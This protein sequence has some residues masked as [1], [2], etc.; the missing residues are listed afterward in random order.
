M[1]ARFY[2]PARG[3]PPGVVLVPLAVAAVPLFDAVAAMA[4]R[5]RRGE[6]PFRGDATSH[7]GHRLL[8][9]GVGPRLTVVLGTGFAAA[10]AAAS[11][12]MYR[13]GGALLVGL[14]CLVGAVLAGMA[15]ARAPH[16]PD[17]GEEAEAD[18]AALGAAG[19]PAESASPADAEEAAASD[20]AAEGDAAE[21][22]EPGPG[23]GDRP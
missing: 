8:A 6:N 20:V 23:Q 7:F 10:T 13:F 9:K 22:S 3:T 14:W 11:V 12:F 2:F 1:A 4:A 17:E 15:L 16:P 18:G 21:D 5:V 19:P